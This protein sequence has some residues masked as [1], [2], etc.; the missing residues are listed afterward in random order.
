MKIRTCI[1]PIIYCFLMLNACAFDIVRVKQ[2][3]VPFE[4]YH[5]PE[6]L[7]ELQEETTVSLGTGYNRTL[8][9]KTKWEYVGKISYG[10]VFRTKDQVLT[11][12]ASNIFE[13]YIVVSSEKLVGFY[14]PVEKSFSPLSDPKVLNMKKIGR[15]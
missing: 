4:S 8:K 10:D 14:L 13:A 6:N 5:N 15:K 7:L 3:P 9:A 1:I 2:I 12:E 11:V